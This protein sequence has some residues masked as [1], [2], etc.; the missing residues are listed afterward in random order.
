MRFWRIA[1]VF[2]FCAEE[3]AVEEGEALVCRC[4]GVTCSK[5]R[6]LKALLRLY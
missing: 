3:S 4:L 6:T 1:S 2:F 5:R